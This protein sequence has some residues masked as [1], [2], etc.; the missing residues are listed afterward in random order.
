RPSAS[1]APAPH[2]AAVAHTPKRKA[3]SLLMKPKKMMR[4]CSW[5]SLA[6]KG[7][8]ATA[9]RLLA[10]RRHSRAALQLRNGRL[11]RFPARDQVFTLALVL[12]KYL[13]HLR[14]RSGIGRFHNVCQVGILRI[15]HDRIHK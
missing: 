11:H 3:R 2:S 15:Q 6:T 1:E 5:L 14:G 9:L 13:I 7:T 12:L 8:R 10:A 4:V